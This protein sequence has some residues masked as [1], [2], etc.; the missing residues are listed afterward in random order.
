MLHILMQNYSKKHEKEM[1]MVREM[2]IERGVSE[3][4]ESK[5]GK[6]PYDLCPAQIG[7]KLQE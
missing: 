4:K 3:E 5:K 7:K 6:M 2:L 1:M